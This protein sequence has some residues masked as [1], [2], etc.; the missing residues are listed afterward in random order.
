MGRGWFGAIADGPLRQDRSRSRLPS[1][2]Q[3]IW[4]LPAGHYCI[5]APAR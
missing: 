3:I 5:D 2:W 4:R 1:R